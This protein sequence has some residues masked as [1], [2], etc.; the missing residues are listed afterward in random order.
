MKQK[1]REELIWK[2]LDGLCTEAE[3]NH[4]NNRIKTDPTFAKQIEQLKML[5]N[6][7]DKTV[8]QS[9][10]IHLT[11]S[12]LARVNQQPKIKP[13]TFSLIPAMVVILILLATTVYFLPEAST[14]LSD[15]IPVDWNFLALNFK[16]SQKYLPYIFGSFAAIA[17]IWIDYFYT[18]KLSI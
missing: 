16:I 14:P 15:Y 13:A 2:H 6:S 4:L 1:Y 9:A 10:P 3:T 7:I 12:I 18:R 11:N 5:D 8:L 17:L